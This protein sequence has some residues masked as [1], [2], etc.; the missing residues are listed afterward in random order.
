MDSP[1]EMMG[2]VVKSH[3]ICF[4]FQKTIHSADVF[5][6]PSRAFVRLAFRLLCARLAVHNFAFYSKQQ[7]QRVEWLFIISLP[8]FTKQ[9]SETATFC[10]FERTKTTMARLNIKTEFKVVECKTRCRWPCCRCCLNCLLLFG[11]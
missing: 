7:R 5:Y 6:T 2:N 9:Q 1:S 3:L 11:R 8:F 10:V 4:D